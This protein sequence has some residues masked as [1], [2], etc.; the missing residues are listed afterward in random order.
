MAHGVSTRIG[1]LPGW[2][3]RLESNLMFRMTKIGAPGEIARA[4]ALVPR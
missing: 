1:T 3:A 2:G 4:G